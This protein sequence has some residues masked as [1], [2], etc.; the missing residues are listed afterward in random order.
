[1]EWVLYNVA[2]EK[3]C[4]KSLTGDIYIRCLGF[5]VTKDE[6][7]KQA[8]TINNYF[9][10]KG[11][12]KIE[13]RIV[14]TKEFRMLLNENYSNGNLDLIHAREIKKLDALIQFHKDHLQKQLK[15]VEFRSQHK[16]AGDIL[17][18]PDER[19][20]YYKEISNEIFK[21]EIKT[22]EIK[23]PEIKTPQ[24]K[25]IINESDCIIAKFP[26]DLQIRCQNFFVF[27]YLKDYI[28]EL[29]DSNRIDRWKINLNKEKTL[30]RN[31]IFIKLLKEN[32]DYKPITFHEFMK[33]I[34]DIDSKTLENK[35][36]IYK[37]NLDEEYF[38]FLF[39]DL[40][41]HSDYLFFQQVLD[42]IEKNYIQKNPVPEKDFKDEP[43]LC[44][45]S[46]GNTEDDINV[47]IK[48]N[49]HIKICKDYDIACVSMY[50]WIRIKNFNN[51]LIKKEYNENFLNFLYESRKNELLEVEKIKEN[52]P[53]ILIKNVF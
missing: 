16:I 5:F 8:K 53:E 36:E 50:E 52:N 45:L 29:C 39:D 40:G 38:K 23:T 15:D 18:T 12:C 10:S 21:N 41:K 20:T 7:M 17:F 47:W 46:V 24:I 28:N 22:P 43:A 26:Y 49:K 32:L 2:C 44:F 30:Y 6:A 27:A 1:M 11:E 13:I 31:E 37:S 19:R 4:I 51:S 35:T 3:G 25:T 48:Q 34:Y 9:E 33:Q 42:E 14:K